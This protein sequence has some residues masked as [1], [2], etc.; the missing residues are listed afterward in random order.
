MAEISARSVNNMNKKQIAEHRKN[1]YCCPFCGSYKV[2]FS[3]HFYNDN[4]I[5]LRRGEC[6]SCYEKFTEIYTLSDIKKN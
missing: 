3:H 5:V 1:M 6:D 4:G 2:D